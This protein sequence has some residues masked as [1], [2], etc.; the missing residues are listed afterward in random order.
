MGQEVYYKEPIPGEPLPPIT[1]DFKSYFSLDQGCQNTEP[2]LR[3]S[4]VSRHFTIPQYTPPFHLEP[5]PCFIPED[6][7][8]AQLVN[9]CVKNSGIIKIVG[10]LAD[11]E[12]SDTPVSL[13]SQ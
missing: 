11:C 2:I 4:P 6:P 9:A 3:A 7:D 8:P 12:V 1:N 10:D 13:L 5:E